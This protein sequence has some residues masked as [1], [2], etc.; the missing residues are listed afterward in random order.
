MT[1]KSW[2]RI[3][4][5]ANILIVLFL[6][7]KRFYYTRYQIFENTGK[8]ISA[9]K[10]D[11]LRSGVYRYLPVDSNDIV[12]I[13]TS[14]TQ[15]FPYDE[16][17]TCKIKNR[18]TGSNTSRLMIGRIGY[19]APGKPKVIILESGINDF[20]IDNLSPDEAFRRISLMVET[21][22]KES[23]ATRILLQS[24]LPTAGEF[25]SYMPRIRDLNFKLL[26][27]AGVQGL[28]YIDLYSAL[29]GDNGLHPDYSEDGLHP[30]GRGYNVMARE[31]SSHLQ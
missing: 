25:K 27:Y 23:P 31:L 11:Y 1:A 28:T 16:L 10:Y 13:G 4:V 9:E 6:I 17:L 14:I 2:L 18:G 21:I 3:S 22:K 29:G 15:G 5:A 30:N 19:I 12:A 26:S 20:L 7:G 24:V 8:K